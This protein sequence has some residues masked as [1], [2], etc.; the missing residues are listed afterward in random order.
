MTRADV[1]PRQIGK[2]LELPAKVQATGTVLLKR[3]Y[4]HHSATEHDPKHMM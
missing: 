2:K 3:F 1:A 4:L